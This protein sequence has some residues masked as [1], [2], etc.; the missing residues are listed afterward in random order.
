MRPRLL[1]LLFAL[2][3]FAAGNPSLDKASKLYAEL[4]YTEAGKA[5]DAALK[6]PGNDRAS[7]LKILELQGVVV[8]TLGQTEKAARSFEQ[9]LM[10][11][12]DFKLSGNYPPRVT[13]AFYEARGWAEAN[14]HLEVKPLDAVVEPGRI[15]GVRLEVTK[16]PL[17]QVK[18]VRFHFEHNGSG[19][20]VTATLAGTLA[21]AA[22][23]AS[24]LELS[25]WA[26][27]LG[28]KG[29]VL[30]EV[31]SSAAPKLEKAPPRPPDA[32]GQPAPI[33]QPAPIGPA[34]PIGQPTPIA[35]PEEPTPPPVVISPSP[36]EPISG[37]RI[38]AFALF[39]GAAVAT[40]L[41]I[42][43]GVNAKS[44]GAQVDG[45]TKNT[46]GQVT[47]L[48]QVQAF[49]L[50]ARQRTQATLSNVF[51]VSAIA[52]AAGGGALLYLSRGTAQPHVSLVPTG[53]G[54]A[55]VGTFP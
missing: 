32:P 16:D 25:W 48:T 33:A 31:G 52:L 30:V 50:D 7:L 46:A 10:L 14:A 42:V 24:T 28:D 20:E 47:N 17:K 54:M 9:L 21:T 53:P 43:F 4:N 38:G 36:A 45:A 41:G 37:K 22:P 11:A 39:G 40:G 13:T 1:P 29:A 18:N 35:Q 2:P 5:V 6:Q 44:A 12:P 49:E 19:S 55:I 8:A 27:V 23:P 15:K 26:E 51:Y 34:A 3:A